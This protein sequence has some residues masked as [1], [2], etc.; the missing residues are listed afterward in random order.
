M[1]IM[2][3]PETGADDKRPGPLGDRGGSPVKAIE[4]LARSA[5]ASA[6]TV[7]DPVG[8]GVTPTH[9]VTHGFG[10]RAARHGSDTRQALIAGQF[11]RA[12][13]TDLSVKL[14]IIG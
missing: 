1:P 2:R 6:V 14:Y 8:R 11:R 5:R 3:G 7:A 12:T 4:P 13:E 10:G 9:A